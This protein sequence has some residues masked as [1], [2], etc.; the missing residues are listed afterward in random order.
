[1]SACTVE[2]H[3]VLRADRVSYVQ[4]TTLIGWQ[5]DVAGPPFEM[6]TCNRCGST[7]SD[8][9]RRAFTQLEWRRRMDQARAR[10]SRAA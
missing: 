5:E 8:G 1:M 2:S 6:R 9:T 3:T 7:L 4:G 10:V